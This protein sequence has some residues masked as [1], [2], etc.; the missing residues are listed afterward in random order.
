MNCTGTSIL[1]ILLLALFLFAGTVAATTGGSISGTVSDPT[2]A[3]IAY[4]KVVVRD[5]DRSV[6]RTVNTND[7]GFYAF[8]FLPV[9]RYAIE[10][11]REGF[12]PYSVTGLVIDIGSA[13]KLDA[14]LEV[15]EHAEAVT[16]VEQGAQVETASAFKGLSMRSTCRGASIRQMRRGEPRL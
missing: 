2:G 5:L 12:R 8:T 10:I 11:R 3:V 16:V 6:A 14:T 4:A 9:G 1:R 13:L 7:T 15:G